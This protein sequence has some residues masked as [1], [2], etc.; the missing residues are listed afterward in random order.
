[1]NNIE[2]KRGYYIKDFLLYMTVQKNLA[3]RT[4]KAYEHD[5]TKFFE[6]LSP[7][8]EKELT[9]SEIDHRTVLEFLSYLK[10]DRKNN[11]R[12][13]NRKISAIKSYFNYLEKEGFIEH[14]PLNKIESLKPPK[15]LPKALEMNEVDVLINSVDTSPRETENEIFRKTRD[16]AIMELFYATGL[17]IS[18][19]SSLKLS[20]INFDT[21]SARV[22]GKG[23]KERIVFINNVALDAVKEYMLV[24]PKDTEVENL[25]ISQKG[26]AMTVRAIQHMFSKY[27]KKS[28]IPWSSP[29]AMRH[30]F[31]TH[32]LEGGADLVTIKELL[33]HASL[34]TT[35]IYLDVSRKRLEYV[36]KEAHPRAKEDISEIT[37]F[38]GET[39][40]NLNNE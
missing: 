25:F 27:V 35:Q 3:S 22:I 23:N 4:I 17:R 7:Y 34:A 13:L 29:H 37:E 1:M 21:A 32:M 18:E 20:Q 30:S 40:K 26:G 11:A 9:L 31:A 39:L 19:L 24:R 28:A 16:K 33:G 6:F 5:L 12:S 14:S 38:S 8:L 15:R 2:K 10:L 36:Y